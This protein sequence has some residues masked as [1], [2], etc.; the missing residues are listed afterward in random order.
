MLA[1]IDRLPCGLFVSS[2]IITDIVLVG[3]IW[4]LFGHGRILRP[5]HFRGTSARELSEDVEDR[6]NLLCRSRAILTA[7]V[8]V[9]NGLARDPA[10]RP[11]YSRPG[12]D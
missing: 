6:Q 9:G 5:G 2:F 3:C 11:T 8:E 12:I 7:S 10:Y 4:L 1:L